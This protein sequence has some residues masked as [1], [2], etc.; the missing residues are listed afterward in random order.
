[1][2]DTSSAP[3][4][5]EAGERAF[6]LARRLALSTSEPADLQVVMDSEIVA[7]ASAHRGFHP[8]NV[9]RSRC[10]SQNPLR[11]TGNDQRRTSRPNRGRQPL[12]T[13]DGV[14]LTRKRHRL[15]GEQAPD[16]LE[17]FTQALDPHTRTIQRNTGALIVADL[18]T[19]TD[20]QLETP[21][22]PAPYP[23][24]TPC[25]LQCSSPGYKRFSIIFHE[26]TI[27]FDVIVTPVG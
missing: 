27:V 9:G 4:P 21:A 26:Y 23:S 3:L 16:D 10:Q 6:A 20:T 14:V 15:A 18:P 24:P 12:Q 5:I 11:T 19:R 7:R 22:S 8:H 13:V 17:R 1:M 25:Q 2:A